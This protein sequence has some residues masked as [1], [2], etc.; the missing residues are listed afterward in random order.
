MLLLQFSPSCHNNNFVPHFLQNFYTF[1]GKMLDAPFFTSGIME[2]TIYFPWPVFTNLLQI[3]VDYPTKT[4]LAVKLDLLGQSGE[5]Q[6]SANPVMEPWTKTE[7]IKFK[8][9]PCSINGL[10]C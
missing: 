7:G 3:E 8:K 10:L 1:H 2:S 9:D 5:K 4:P 6:Y